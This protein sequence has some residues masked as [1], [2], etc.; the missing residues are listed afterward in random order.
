MIIIPGYQAVEKLY[1]SS[2]SLIYRAQRSTDHIPVILKVLRQEYPSPKA[3]A[4]F[5][6]EY[7]IL[8]RL[9]LAG[10]IT[11]YGLE[12]YQQNHMI[13][14]EDF[15]GQSLQTYWLN[16]LAEQPSQPLFNLEEF[17]ILAIQL[18]KILGEIHQQNIIHKDIN[19]SNIVL[20]TATGQV[21]IIDFGLATI[22]SRENPTFRNPNVLE[23]TLAYMSP[24]Q[25]GR[26]N[27]S[28]DYRTDFYSLGATFYQ[29]LCD[30]LPFV[31]TDALEL[32]HCHISR[33][34]ISPQEIDA[35]I[36]HLLSD[37]VMKLL[38]K[39]AEDRYQSTLGIQADLQECFNQL[40][41]NQQ[42]E[43]WQIGCRDISSTF[44]IPQKIYGREREI[45]RLLA[46][47]EGVCRDF[48]S[49]LLLISGCAGIGKTTLVRELYKPITHQRGYFIMGKYEQLQRNIPYSALIQ[50]F[51]ELIRQLLTE[52]TAH[53]QYWRAQ[54]LAALGDNARVAIDVIPDLELLIGQQP[55]AIELPPAE[56]QNRFHLVLENFIGVFAQTVIADEGQ[57]VRPLVIFLDDLQWADRAS[58][59]LIE[60]WM[61]GFKERYLLMIGAYRDNE[62]DDTHPLIRAITTIQL[63][64][65][66]VEWIELSTLGLADVHDL[67]QDTIHC[68]FSSSLVLAEL[69]LKKT[70]GNPFFVNEFLRYL[71]RERMIEFDFN[72]G[73]WRWDLDRIQTAK[74]ADNVVE[75]VTARL[76]DLPIETQQILSVAACIGNQFNLQTLAIVDN[77][78][79]D[80]DSE[81]LLLTANTL[82][83][84]S[85]ENL[86]TPIGEDYKYLGVY[87]RLDEIDFDI[88][89]KFLH[90]R[91]QQAAYGLIS[92]DRQIQYHLAIGRYLWQSTPTEC[93]EDR[94][95][96]I[97]DHLNTGAK[98]I[99]EQVQKNELA[100]LNLMAGRK[101]KSA[102]AY[103]PAARYFTTGLQF[104]TLLS[105]QT[106]YE[107]TLTL[108][109]EATE[110][111]FLSLNFERAKQLADLTIE[112]AVSV[113]DRIRIYE[114]QMQFYAQQNQLQVTLD[115]GLQVLAMLDISLSSSGR[116]SPNESLVPDIQPAVLANLPLM[117]DPAKLAAIRILISLAPAAYVV[118]PD[119]FAQ[120][121]NI[122]INL[123]LQHGNSPLAAVAYGFRG[124]MLCAD[125]TGVELGYQFAQLALQLLERFDVK[126]FK[127]HIYVIF[128]GHIRHW[129]EHLRK[130]IPALAE[131]VQSGLET[132]SLEYAG[133][134]ALY[135]SDHLFF[136]GEPLSI[137]LQ[138]QTQQLETML[139]LRQDVHISYLKIWRVLLLKLIN[140]SPENYDFHGELLDENDLL[141]WSI[142]ADKKMF[143]SAAYLSR[144]IW[145][146]LVRDYRQAIN[147]AR[148]ATEYQAG[149]VGLVMDAEHTFYYALALLASVA[150]NSQSGQS[151]SLEIVAKQQQK[152]QE[153]SVH[154]P[155][156]YLHKFHLIA[157]ERYRI[158]GQDLAA[159]DAYDLAIDL[160][161][162]HEYL[163]EEAL[164]NELAG[165]FYLAK[166]RSKIAQAYLLDARYCYL[167]WGAI[168]K[169]NDLDQSYPQ[170]F[171]H[172]PEKI[173]SIAISQNSVSTHSSNETA[174]LDLATLMKAAQALSG[175]IVLEKLLTKLMTIL[176]ENSGAQRGCLILDS[177]GK[178]YIA[179]TTDVESNN[180]II[181]TAMPI[182]N[183]IAQTQ[184]P[185]TI[186]NYV[187]RTRESI[188]LDRATQ[189][190]RFNQDSYI[191]SHQ[192]QSILCTPLVYQGKRSGIL[193]LENNLTTDTFMPERLEILQFLSTQAAISLENAQLYNQLELRV[194]ER[195]QE[196]TQTN[197]L[198]QAEVLERQKSEQILRSIVEGTASVTG[199]EFFRSLVRSLAQALGVRYA[200][201]SE[202]LDALPIRVRSFAFWQ[203]NDFGDEFE[204]YLHG[205]PC[206][207]VL[208]SKGYQC[209]SAQ[210]QTLFPTEKD[211]LEAMQAQSYAGIALLDSSGNLLGHL[212]ILDDKPMAADARM[213]AILEIF[214]A[215]AA[216]EMERQQAE[217]AL[218]VSETKFS[219]AFGSSPDAI[220]ISTL[221]D[222]SYLEV[223]ES[224]LQMLG[225][226]REEMLG[227][228]ALNL[229]IWANPADREVIKQQ[230]QQQGTVTNLE[231]WFRR[232][233]GESFPALF[234]A[235]VIQLENRSCVLAVATDITI[236]KQAEKALSR[237]AEIGEL[238]ATIVHEV[239][240]PLTT[241]MMG[242]N[243]FKKLQLADRFQEYLNLSLE[244]A[245]RLQR[246]LSQILLYSKPQML[247]RSPLELNSFILETVNTLQTIPVALGKHLEFV[248]LF[249][250]ANVLADRD[251]FKQVL[252]NLI[253]NAYEAINT[254]DVI[255][256]HLLESDNHLVCIQIHNGGVP[257][258]EDI[259][260]QLTKPFFTTKASG[261]GLGLA[262]VK[263]IVE[264]HEGEFSIESSAESG[265]IVKV[266]IPLVL[267]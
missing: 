130:S 163:Q 134:N 38:A 59:Q 118:A 81:S 247:E 219:T 88:N 68:Q 31:T 132:G 106:D 30:R 85:Q 65:G 152:M 69:T 218:R 136:T 154:A 260:P 266:K 157:A 5:Q 145:F 52:T 7:E 114:I 178:L 250:S 210:I 216:A 264:A 155:M 127:S 45:D 149:I 211:E 64:A 165:R 10:V 161:K 192:P 177:N 105:W 193:Y 194:Q 206:E 144:M 50:A 220:T 55:Q 170:F 257:I 225:Y 180:A 93:L 207:R 156:N 100:R 60:Q 83:I 187:S 151:Q 261:T 70:N 8:H 174:A 223:N 75:L 49:E 140:A 185:L 92:V 96:D 91:I 73:I 41:Q 224:C 19:P 190:Y 172:L 120:I 71:D 12:T 131:G 27:R 16:S 159:I 146:Y 184:V 142:A 24:E 29:L 226:C 62:V 217:D 253:T 84:A 86:I 164:A 232:K 108:Y 34:P 200:F 215:R 203:G 56:L 124:L 98:L 186:I 204:Y 222:G 128:N 1:E 231:I 111:E 77:Q 117:T 54:L 57:S 13:V 176:M 78:L 188:V 17:L 112:H 99:V 179:A 104:L 74:L 236:L 28:I 256:I 214:A 21:K 195:T 241:I 53:I 166:G 229:E 90:D 101:A 26:M 242:L 110:T 221:N 244:E 82:H 230:L 182:D 248:S 148:L 115:L 138:Q 262:I 135:L 22:L 249:K 139:K 103:E 238:A 102:I 119:L 126:K 183:E 51:R 173:S 122:A 199:T 79:A 72:Q 15:G 169:V 201:I 239:R 94:I 47:L 202:C 20:N 48:S 237:L 23:G 258:P 252:I 33:R 44:Q 107:L 125:P 228:N 263:R 123:C 43:G 109:T 137:V 40:Q 251:K 167:R 80:C 89:Y 4:R 240:N 121:P 153:W 234:S 25:T 160:A 197:D 175:E 191:L 196:L 168:A 162:E 37:L 245:D 46:A 235:E 158:L 87:T 255:T 11:A 243:A 95:F 6:I 9:N 42:I 227:H 143:V 147:C 2:R 116:F 18:T 58:L 113:L 213:Q 141:N 76:Q 39:N 246:L 61:S 66:K 233:S 63:A 208:K 212:A 3:I 67:I 254:G 133:Y 198:L 205:T 36:P 181:L 259:L 129:K 189:D 32:V 171:A 14:L 265:S 267:S 209:F 97:I 35:T 150:G